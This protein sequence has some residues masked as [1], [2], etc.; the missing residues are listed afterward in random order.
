MLD[1]YSKTVN[2]V[3]VSLGNWRNLRAAVFEQATE[4][5]SATLRSTAFLSRL[6]VRARCGYEADFRP[7]GKFDLHSFAEVGK[8]SPH[9][10]DLQR[11]DFTNLQSQSS[12]DDHPTQHFFRNLPTRIKSASLLR[13]RAQRLRA[14]PVRLS[15]LFRNDIIPTR[16]SGA[17]NNQRR[18][19]EPAFTQMAFPKI[20]IVVINYRTAQLTLDCLASLEPEV[21]ARPGAN[22][23]LVDSA[24]GDGSADFLESESSSRGWQKWLSLIR[25]SENR[26]FSAGNNRGIAFAESL[27]HFDGFLLL[28]SDTIV[29]PGS[30]GLLSEVLERNPSVG[31]VGSRLEW[32]DGQ[33]QVSCF[34]KISPTSELLAAAKT[35]P[36]SR[37]FFGQEV[38]IT[39][40]P[41]HAA[42]AT[43]RIA[44]LEQEVDWISFACVLIRKEVISAIGPMDEGFF[45][46]FEDVDYCLRAR[47]AG[48]Q[49]AF[50]PAARVVHLRGGRTST[51]FAIEERRRRPA[52]YYQARA[53]YLAKYFGLTGPW[54]ANLCWHLGR[55]ISLA[56]EILGSKAP[57]TARRE[58]GDIWKGSLCGF[59]MAHS[60]AG[61][62]RNVN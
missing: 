57:H 53:R 30:L 14:G 54:R 38:A 35:G 29:R 9:P 32:P 58:A 8:V 48:W 41:A 33:V 28:N 43:H 52:Y 19:I 11:P 46:Y 60:D 42:T 24:S 7:S 62:G 37:L 3:Q 44:D 31:L 45:M 59:R 40:L 39:D 49:I 26:G 2:S 17:A 23:V 56:R 5:R 50:E 13:S 16:P 12:S 6:C 27:G 55:S 20:A 25:L 22:V 34:R 36:V 51:D 18:R 1:S 47:R 4:C 10:A 61:G 21:N 15:R